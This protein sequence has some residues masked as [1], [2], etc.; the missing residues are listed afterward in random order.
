MMA[1]RKSSSIGFAVS[2]FML[3]CSPGNRV[4]LAADS[5]PALAAVDNSDDSADSGQTHDLRTQLKIIPVA[6]E[7]KEVGCWAACAVMIHQYHGQHISQDEIA[8]EIMGTDAQGRIKMQA[9]AHSQIRLALNP[10]LYQSWKQQTSLRPIGNSRTS[11]SVKPS[12]Y[13]NARLDESSIDSDDIV[14]SLRSR[15]PVVVVLDEGLESELQHAYVMYGVRYAIEPEPKAGWFESIPAKVRDEFNEKI[16]GKKKARAQR[17][18]IREVMLIDPA[19]GAEI[20]P[21]PGAEFKQRV[22]MMISKQKAREILEE[23]FKSVQVAH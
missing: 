6:Q 13:I 23:E 18:G 14:E 1:I 12:H 22:R 5:S 21:M 2:L 10:D 19:L 16:G 11:I 8:R 4:R 3:G 17:Y 15:D 9:A 20:P 7:D